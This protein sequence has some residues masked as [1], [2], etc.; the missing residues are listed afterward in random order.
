MAWLNYH[1]LLYFWT[2]ART[3]SVTKACQ[4]LNLTQPAVSA[5]IRMLERSLG[6]K[7]FVKRGRNLALTDIGRLV[8]RYADEIFV[9]GREMQ[10]TLAGK[11]TGQP[12]R[13]VVGVADQVPKAII[14]R[15]LEPA[16][17]A[18]EP[19][20]LI[21]REDGLDRLLG[22]LAMHSV[23]LV[24]SDAPI[25]GTTRVRAYNHLLGETDVTIFGAPTLAALYKK[26]FPAS[27][28]GAP[29]ILPTSGTQLHRSLMSWFD[30]NNLRPMV[31]AEIE[32]SA[33]LKMFGQGGIG[34]FAG[35]TAIQDEIVSRYDVKPVGR[36]EA[37]KERFYAI[38]VERKITHP[39]VRQI[40]SLAQQTLF[41]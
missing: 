31:V 6:E 14:Y 33:L 38:S 4:E 12:Q 29:L 40:S 3:G 35:P 10:E 41:G 28:D 19:V 5:Q 1:H 23:D 34:L 16:L 17:R 24:I 8:Y 26:R 30:S 32:D 13:L 7:L 39:V 20:R 15:L 9:L 27:L 11:V 21:I 36:I 2:V 18:S 37:V 25:G 22:D